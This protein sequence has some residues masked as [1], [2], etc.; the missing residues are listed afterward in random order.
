M[1]C[2][3]GRVM[4]KKHKIFIGINVLVIIAFVIGS[5]LGVYKEKVAKDKRHLAWLYYKQNTALQVKGEKEKYQCASEILLNNLAIELC[6]YNTMQSKYKLTVDEVTEYL[7]EEYDSN[8][9][10]KIYSQ[11]ENISDYIEWNICRSIDEKLHYLSGFIDYLQEHGYSKTYD[12]MSYEEVETAL[13]AY[14]N[15]PEYDPYK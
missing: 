3:Q 1:R 14:V 15:D 7:S 11:P 8:G 5:F 13:E 2:M 4:D 10:L 6:A 12:E 9:K